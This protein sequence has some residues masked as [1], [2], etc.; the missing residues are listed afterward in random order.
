MN[1]QDA[2]SWPS[3]RALSTAGWRWSSS[4]RK[5]GGGAVFIV[6]GA[7]VPG[8]TSRASPQRLAGRLAAMDKPREIAALLESEYRRV[9]AALASSLR[10]DAAAEEEP[11]PT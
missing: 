5:A 9:L 1:W 2:R 7:A 11:R 3:A 8:N 10:V 6:S 4:P